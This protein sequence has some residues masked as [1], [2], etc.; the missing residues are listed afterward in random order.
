MFSYF[1]TVC[2]NKLIL[3]TNLMNNE[4]WSAYLYRA[5]DVSYYIHKWCAHNNPADTGR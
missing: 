1:T 3:Y 2:K 4:S 5:I